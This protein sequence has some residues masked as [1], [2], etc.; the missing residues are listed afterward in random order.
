VKN[1]CLID[2]GELREG[3]RWI[4]RDPC[5]RYYS[6]EFLA[7]RD[8]PMALTRLCASSRP[9]PHHRR[10][11]PQIPAMT[12][13]KPRSMATSTS[14]AECVSRSALSAARRSIDPEATPPRSGRQGRAVHHTHTL[15]GNPYAGHISRS[16]RQSNDPSA[17]R[18]SGSTWISAIVDTMRRPSNRPLNNKHRIERNYL[19]HRAH[20]GSD[21]NNAPLPP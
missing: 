6:E 19:H 10:R 13:R 17:T 16:F 2:R 8:Q 1:P 18:S 20:R 9:W 11:H 7:L 14:P 3:Q 5:Y 12:R 21:A 4:L 15:P